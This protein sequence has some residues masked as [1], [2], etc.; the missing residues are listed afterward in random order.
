MSSAD[1]KV[2]DWVVVVLTLDG[3]LTKEGGEGGTAQD[4]GFASDEQK[5]RT[6]SLG[7]VHP[8]PGPVTGVSE[9]ASLRFLG[10]SGDGEVINADE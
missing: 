6:S 10:P 9:V 5:Y 7:V 2:G 3:I 4:I 8:S 1:L